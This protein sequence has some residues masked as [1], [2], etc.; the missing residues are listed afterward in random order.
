[1]S[2]I[3]DY[4]KKK[5]AHC[6]K[7][8]DKHARCAS[9]QKVF[10]Y[11]LGLPSAII[12]GLVGTSVYKGIEPESDYFYLTILASVVAACLT[13]F[14]TVLQPGSAQKLHSEARKRYGKAIGLIQTT[15]VRYT[16]DE[17]NFDLSLLDEIE[18]LI[19]EATDI[20]PI[21]P[22]RIWDR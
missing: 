20:E 19:Q 8:S 10:G 4:L 18:R 16:K 3:I 1:M 12:S 11:M 17:S 13:A 5:E 22:N 21:I 2:D 7:K 9:S 6:L 14:Q 15:K